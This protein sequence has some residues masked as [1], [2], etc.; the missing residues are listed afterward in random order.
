MSSSADGSLGLPFEFL[1]LVF[2]HS[3]STFG[4]RVRGVEWEERVTAGTGTDVI[5]S[6]MGTSL[7][8][9]LLGAMAADMSVGGRAGIVLLF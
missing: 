9:P 8:Y 4:L 2:G 7:G 6:L 5:T 1:C 3:F